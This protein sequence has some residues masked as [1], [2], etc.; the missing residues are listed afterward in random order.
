MKL[1]S[2][3]KALLWEEL[4][5]G[6]SIV[7]VVFVMSAFVVLSGR[8][9]ASVYLAHW[10]D[11]DICFYVIV[12]ATSFL[13]LLRIGN[14]G[15]MHIGIPRRILYLPVS[16]FLVVTVSLFTRL[17]LIV[18]F[19]LCARFVGA[20]LLFNIES[21][22]LHKGYID[23][24][25]NIFPIEIHFYLPLIF[26]SIIH[27]IVYLTL[28]FLCWFFV[29]SPFLA[30]L[31]IFL[32]VFTWLTLI[33]LGDIT[34]VNN[35]IS[36]LFGSFP[37]TGAEYGGKISYLTSNYFLF[38]GWIILYTCLIWFLSVKITSQVRAGLRRDF[39]SLLPLSF[40]DVLSKL[41]IDIFTKR[42]PNSRIAQLWFELKNNGL[43]IPVWTFIFWLLLFILYISIM[44]LLWAV[45]G[46]SSSSYPYSQDMLFLLFPLV[47][48]VLS[49][50]VWHL[51]VTRRRGRD[52]KAGVYPLSHIPI[53]C[54]ERIYAYW[55][56]GNINLFITLLV[57]WLVEFVYLYWKFKIHILPDP[58]MADLFHSSFQLPF[59]GMSSFTIP[60]MTFITGVTI[61]CGVIVWLIMFNPSSIL[62][63][64]F[65][66]LCL[67]VYFYPSVI[68]F[69]I[70]VFFLALYSLFRIGEVIS[71]VRD[72]LFILGWRN[73]SFLSIVFYAVY[74]Y[75]FIMFFVYLFIAFRA[76]LLGKKER[77]Y[78][79]TIILSIFVCIMPWKYLERID[80][81][82]LVSTYLFLSAIFAMTWLKI[83]LSVYGYHWRTPIKIFSESCLDV[84]KTEEKVSFLLIGYLLPLFFAILTLISHF[85]A[86][87]LN[88]YVT[89]FKENSLPATLGEM[90][91][92]YRSVSQNENLAKK[93]TEL[94]PLGDKVLM[95]E[96]KFG[97]EHQ[98][99]I[100]EKFKTD[101]EKEYFKMIFSKSYDDI[102][103]YDKPIPENILW[104]YKEVYEKIYKELTEKLHEIAESGLNTGYYPI[105]LRK[106]FHTELNHLARIRDFMRK[107][108]LEA[109]LSAIDGD[110]ENMLRAFRSSVFVC[111]SLK[112]EPVYISQLVR[113]S[114][115]GIVYKNVQW[116][117]NHQELPDEV[118]LKLSSIIHDFMTPSEERSLFNLSL[119]TELLMVL[120][121]IPMHHNEEILNDYSSWRWRYGYY[122][123]NQLLQI[124]KSWIPLFDVLYPTDIERMVAVNLYT[125]LRKTATKVARE[126]NIFIPEKCFLD[127]YSSSLLEKKEINSL[128]TSFPPYWIYP[129]VR[130]TYPAL[131]RCFDA[132]L[133]HYVLINLVQTAIAIERFR[134]KNN[135]LPE[136]LQ[137][138]VPDYISA[139]PK[140]PWKNGEPITYIKE[141]N[142]AFKIY[143]IGMDRE[144]DGGM[145]K[146]LKEG[147][148]Q[149]IV[150]TMLPLNIRQQPDVSAEVDLSS[151][152]SNKQ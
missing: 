142:F 91:E 77:I 90:N 89:Y 55:L 85:Q 135:R 82:M 147:R 28:Q 8:L 111:K 116:I 4:Y 16:S 61:T 46:E 53:T 47:A 40:P 138:L 140:D 58:S 49:G 103:K 125:A 27:G 19:T 17:L 66:I 42:F 134:L 99:E 15:E 43:I 112:N 109:I 67:I 98:T 6:G 9:F 52:Y 74:F 57:I 104:V 97:K 81:P 131:E 150:F 108:G 139:I 48:L 145:K 149:D 23:A 59:P 130:I 80:V 128:F 117:I 76:R 12:Y 21:H 127:F 88:K 41:E 56:A 137:E 13:L 100:S 29:L 51:K 105:D 36:F 38:F 30:G 79:L 20:S 50:I 143:S 118:L 45:L 110:Y 95:T 93:Y 106:G 25:R 148:E 69:T 121:V 34:I 122:K 39:K 71:F 32:S 18:L 102:M 68:P 83:L 114:M 101:E 124:R 113:I 87:S 31:I 86:G 146:D 14:S 133:R 115:F 2:P 141:D 10:E 84:P 33:I 73:A 107:L 3:W 60:L 78:L 129:A 136:K 92:K 151:F 144:D 126:E 24:F 119:H 26:P 120:S 152:F 123:N 63:F 94:F 7:S 64:S 35:L 72:L 62:I 96:Y 44:F 65:L 22:G 1:N 11:V 70:E 54:K 5:V 37:H 75:C 132:E